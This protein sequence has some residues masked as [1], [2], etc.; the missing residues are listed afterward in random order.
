MPPEIRRVELLKPRG[1]PGYHL[2]ESPLSSGALVELVA[3]PMSVPPAA[4][5]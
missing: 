3:L 1:R 4:P 2:A 5:P